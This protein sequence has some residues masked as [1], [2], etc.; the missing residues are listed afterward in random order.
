MSK[1]NDWTYVVFESLT[2]CAILVGIS[3]CATVA[4][5]LDSPG[6]EKTSGG[7]SVTGGGGCGPLVSPCRGENCRCDHPKKYDPCYCIN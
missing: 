3:W 6:C 1:V 4:Y 7:C 5:A 2:V